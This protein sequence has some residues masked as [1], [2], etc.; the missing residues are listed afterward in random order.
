M[1]KTSIRKRWQKKKIWINQAIGTYAHLTHIVPK[2][3]RQKV[4]DWLIK[5]TSVKLARPPK[6]YI[7]GK[8]PDGINEF[9]FFR[10]ETG[11]GQGTRMYARSIEEAGIPHRF[12]HLNFLD[13]LPRD[14]TS[15]AD[16]LSKKPKYAVNLIHL[17]PD[18]WD[19]AM[20]LF[21]RRYFDRHYNIGVWLWELESLPRPWLRLLDFVDELWVPSEFIARAARKETDKPIT[22]IPYGIEIDKPKLTR[23]D[24]GLPEDQFIALAMFDSHSYVHRKNPMAA[25][26][27]FTEALAGKPDTMLVLKANHPKEKEIELLEKQLKDAR[28]QYKIIRERMSRECLNGLIACSDVFISLHR[29]EGFGLPIAEAMMLGTAVVAT[30]W[31]ANSEFMDETCAGCIGY[32][33]VPVGDRYHYATE[34]SDQWAEP[35][36]HEAAGY[37]KKLYDDPEYRKKLAGNGQAHVRNLLSVEGSGEKMKKRLEEI[38]CS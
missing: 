13:W 3:P 16:K 11:L 23:A 29:S 27:A 18:Q 20:Q 6:A 1:P 12:I 10:E 35:D 33:M 22:V 26:E 31:S 7:P 2:G 19:E 9:G 32:G 25:I 30:N 36:I 4:R 37:L 14:E 34:S 24:L 8:Y 21:P 38:L 5:E 15:F 17:N 28:V